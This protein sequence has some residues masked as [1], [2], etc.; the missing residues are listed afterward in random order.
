MSYWSFPVISA[1]AILCLTLI[2]IT[3]RWRK[4]PT[5][6]KAMNCIWLASL[7][8]GM[9]LGVW[10]MHMFDAWTRSEAVRSADVPRGESSTPPGS[11]EPASAIP[12]GTPV[13]SSSERA[14]PAEHVSAFTGA[15]VGQ[16]LAQRR[17]EG[18]PLANSEAWP[19]VAQGCRLGNYDMTSALCHAATLAVHGW[20]EARAV[21]YAELAGFCDAGYLEKEL[22]LCGTAHRFSDRRTT[23]TGLEPRRVGAHKGL[24]MPESDI[25]DELADSYLSFRGPVRGPDGNWESWADVASSCAR[26]VYAPSSPACEAAEMRES[27]RH[28]GGSVSYEEAASLCDVGLLNRDS[29]ICRA[30]Y[31]IADSSASVGP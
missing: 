21:S 20:G 12:S 4:A 5:A 22:Y 18:V 31:R 17:A 30:A 11:S 23:A 8:A 26:E 3:V 1:G 10:G 2:Y 24:G 29:E 13:L 14:E 25:A 27:G 7:A 6:F 15:Y 9:L 19:A 28:A 16:A